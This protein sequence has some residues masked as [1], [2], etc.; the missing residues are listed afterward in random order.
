MI[1]SLSFIKSFYNEIQ[2]CTKCLLSKSRKLLVTGE[3]E[4]EYPILFL[5]E[6]PGRT[7]DEIGKPF[8]GKAGKILDNLLVKIGFSRKKIFITN[9]VKCRPPSNRKPYKNEIL[10]CSVY[11]KKEIEIL[12][13]KIIV[14]LGATGVQ[15]LSMIGR[16]NYDRELIRYDNV[17]LKEIRGKI[18]RYQLN[19]C[20]IRVISTYHPA[21]CLRNPSLI[22][23]LEEDL[24]K[25]FEQISLQ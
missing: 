1:D 5:G 23:I 11:L 9:A 21:A 18:L 16:L 15:A 14:S 3:G 8:T 12:K 25:A 4:Y 2:G 6:A 13:P 17:R 22:R 24:K 20:T 19:D 7:E 10:T